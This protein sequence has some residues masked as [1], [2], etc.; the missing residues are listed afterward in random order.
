MAIINL[1]QKLFT[2]LKPENIFYLFIISS[3]RVTLW[4][5]QPTKMVVPSDTCLLVFELSLLG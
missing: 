5:Q 3:L 1:S 2:K 4:F